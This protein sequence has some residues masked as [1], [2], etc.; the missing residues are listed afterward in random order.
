MPKPASLVDMAS[1]G[2]DDP[3]GG[4]VAPSSKHLA[5]GERLK[6]QNKPSS[7]IDISADSDKI[8]DSIFPENPPRQE[9]GG[10]ILLDLGGGGGGEGS[11]KVTPSSQKDL[12]GGGGGG[13]SGNLDDLLGGFSSMAPAAKE[14]EAAAPRVPQPG[15]K[16][17]SALIGDLLG[18]GRGRPKVPQP[19][20]NKTSLNQPQQPLLNDLF[21]GAPPTASHSA[22]PFGGG[23]PVISTTGGGGGD[24]LGDLMAPTGRAPSAAAPQLQQ[25]ASERMVEDML[26]NLGGVGAPSVAGVKTMQQQKPQ[27][28]SRPNYNSAF[29]QANPGGGG[30]G[31]GVPP[32]KATF[33]DLLGMK[34]ILL[35]IRLIS[36]RHFQAVLPLAPTL[37]PARLSAR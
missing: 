7:L 27:Q 3:A 18:G 15:T 14:S 5:V 16:G 1:L 9:S 20:S 12:F 4:S 28:Q 31:G 17:E 10:D 21:G 34:D 8:V 37:T 24:L 26:N 2:S 22:D 11:E 35:K 32:S 6:D 23:A 29:F 36:P 19:G 13:S 30:A 25:S 33:D